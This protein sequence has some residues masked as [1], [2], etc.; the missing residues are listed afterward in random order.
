[1]DFRPPSLKKLPDPA[2]DFP[3]FAE[4]YALRVRAFYDSRAKWHRRF[5]RLSGVIVILS[6]VSLPVLAST[7]Y[8][9]K[10]FVVSCA[11]A[12]VAALT[13][14]RAFYRWD[15]GWV[16]L[17]QTELAITKTYSE[18]KGALRDQP[19]P[20]EARNLLIEIAEIRHGE[21]EAFFK[22]LTFPSAK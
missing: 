21:A 13:A 3:G 20:T 12:L 1:V 22:D 19:G 2:E 6:G 5:Y 4:A 15:Q 11:G 8:T 17:R 9:H 18:W 14:L 10:N 7:S 16:L